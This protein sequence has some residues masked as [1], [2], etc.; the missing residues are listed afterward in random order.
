MTTCILGKS[1]NITVKIIIIPGNR[2]I[3][4]ITSKT[5]QEF[6][7]VIVGYHLSRNLRNPDGV[8]SACPVDSI[9]RGK[10]WSRRVSNSCGNASPL[11]PSPWKP[12]SVWEG[13]VCTVWC[14]VR[15][16]RVKQRTYSSICVGMFNLGRRK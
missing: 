2:A 9:Y 3:V 11:G 5:F 7:C 6:H 15:W 1:L 13:V 10:Q 12:P 8:I 4:V 16:I 14:V